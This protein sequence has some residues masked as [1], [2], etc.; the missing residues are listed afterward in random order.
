MKNCFLYTFRSNQK[1]SESQVFISLLIANLTSNL[2]INC[3]KTS[4]KIDFFNILNIAEQAT[5]KI[6]LKLKFIEE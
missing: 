3:V 2:D 5:L 4:L 1:L 6:T